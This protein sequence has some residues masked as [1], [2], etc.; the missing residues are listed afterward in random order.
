M[1]SSSP[2]DLKEYGSSS[3]KI[4]D[5]EPDHSYLPG[6]HRDSYVIT[7][8]RLDKT[9]VLQ[10][11]CKR[12][13][14]GYHRSSVACGPATSQQKPDLCP[15]IVGSQGLNQRRYIQPQDQVY[16]QQV[17]EIINTNTIPTTNPEVSATQ[18]IQQQDTAHNVQMVSR[19]EPQ[20][21]E[22]GCNGR[23]FSTFSNLLRHQREKSGQ[24]TK[25]TCPDC[26]TEFTRTRARNL[27]QYN[28]KCKTQPST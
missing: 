14:L 18:H 25:A 3:K 11:G 27:H 9:A 2:Q 20:C 19:P 23:S 17:P 26:G 12:H 7:T 5:I 6:N 24:A 10:N 28:G 8:S 16:Q 13:K 21:W 4:C 22:H 15:N 1:Q